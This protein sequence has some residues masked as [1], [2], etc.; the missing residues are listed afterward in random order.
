MFNLNPRRHPLTLQADL[1]SLRRR[2][3]E[4]AAKKFLLAQVTL[5]KP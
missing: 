5:R 4:G 1:A 2:L 3:H